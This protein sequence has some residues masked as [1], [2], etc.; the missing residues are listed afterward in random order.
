MAVLRAFCSGSG[1]AFLLLLGMLFFDFNWPRLKSIGFARK[2]EED[3]A[4][5]FPDSLELRLADSITAPQKPNSHTPTFESNL[6][7]PDALPTPFGVQEMRV[8]QT[9]FLLTKY[10]DK[11]FFV[12]KFLL[13]FK[14]NHEFTV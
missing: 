2:D 10:R 1:E 12:G 3:P 4:T 13:A 6:P 11:P 14:V 9:A 7:H 8:S 5:P